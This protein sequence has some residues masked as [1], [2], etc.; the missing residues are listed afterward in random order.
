MLLSVLIQNLNIFKI[1]FTISRK[2]C[3]NFMIV[4]IKVFYEFK[5]MYKNFKLLLY[6]KKV[7]M[8]IFK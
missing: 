3:E 6:L 7:L 1:S 4:K 5:K 2:N 8:R